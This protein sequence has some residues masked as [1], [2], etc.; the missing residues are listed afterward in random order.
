MALYSRDAE[1]F[2]ALINGVDTICN[3]RDNLKLDL[4]ECQYDEERYY[5]DLRQS[6]QNLTHIR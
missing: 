3:E 2:Q 6:R 4:E 5:E 1:T